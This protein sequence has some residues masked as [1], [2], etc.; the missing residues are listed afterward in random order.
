[1]VKNTQAEALRLRAGDIILRYAGKK[2]TTVSDLAEAKQGITS[3]K[4]ELVILRADKEV[5][6]S[7]KPG[8]IGVFTE[9]EYY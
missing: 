7:L 2:I 4:V 5:V 1:M 3:D 9:P 8:Q 6:L